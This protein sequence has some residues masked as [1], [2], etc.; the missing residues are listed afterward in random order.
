[1]E[2][3]QPTQMLGN[4]CVCKDQDRPGPSATESIFKVLKEKD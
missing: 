4:P 1:M 2:N 3:S